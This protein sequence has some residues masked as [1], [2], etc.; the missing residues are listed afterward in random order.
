[1]NEETVFLTVPEAADLLRVSR[2]TIDSWKTR[3]DFPVIKIGQIVR[4]D[5]AELLDWF[6]RQGK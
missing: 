3:P 5:K 4:V 6:K 1:M 2:R